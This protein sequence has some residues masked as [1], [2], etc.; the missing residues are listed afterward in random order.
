MA[1]VNK[2]Q[3]VEDD[4]RRQ[5]IKSSKTEV[6]KRYSQK[7]KYLVKRNVVQTAEDE[8]EEGSHDD[9]RYDA[10]QANLMEMETNHRR[11]K[12][13]V[14]LIKQELGLIESSSDAAV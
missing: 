1:V 12:E 7:N 6:A 4:R 2:P 3:Q 14:D 13:A 9:N 5:Q 11:A 10:I 8:E